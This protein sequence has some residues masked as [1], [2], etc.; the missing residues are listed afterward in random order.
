MK[1][2]KNEYKIILKPDLVGVFVYS[3]IG[4]TLGGTVGAMKGLKVQARREASRV[5]G[6][7]ASINF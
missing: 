1:I 2:G 7:L 4:V 5:T 6:S 3:L